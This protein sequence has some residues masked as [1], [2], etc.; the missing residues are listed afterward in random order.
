ME[1]K[2]YCGSESFFS[3][4]CKPFIE[5][6]EDAP[7]SEKLMRSRYAAYVI[8]NADYL[9]DT[10][11][12]SKRKLHSKED[13][14][15]WSKSNQWIKLEILHVSEDSVEFKAFYIDQ[16]QKEQLHHELSVFQKMNDRWYYVSGEFLNDN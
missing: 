5:G 10:T 11:H 1:G 4:C 12:V 13:I 16:N 14:L 2:C 15:N 3:K 6:N 7:T 9:L 8:Q